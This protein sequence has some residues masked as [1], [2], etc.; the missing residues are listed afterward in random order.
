MQ[1]HQIELLASIQ[2]LAL[3]APVQTGMRVTHTVRGDVI[4]SNGQAYVVSEVR[5]VDRACEEL[6]KT[7]VQV[8][9]DG[10]DEPTTYL[11]LTDSKDYGERTL[12]Q[13][14]DELVEWVAA[15]RKQEAA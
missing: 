11:Y 5:I 14:L 4:G 15:N 3:A 13:Q 1:A 6:H 10:C 12:V 2:A 7:V 8:A 9:E